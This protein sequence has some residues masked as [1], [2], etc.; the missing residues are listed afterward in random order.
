MTNIYIVHIVKKI[1]YIVYTV[2]KNS[3]EDSHKSEN[4][5]KLDNVSIFSMSRRNKIVN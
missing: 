3:H 4:V 2:K 1:V 5:L